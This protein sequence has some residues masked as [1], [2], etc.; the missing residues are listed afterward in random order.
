MSEVWARLNGVVCNVTG[1]FARHC[2]G[3]VVDLLIDL[4]W[5]MACCGAEV[6]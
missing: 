1:S 2:V 5:F 4:R 6:E 3:C